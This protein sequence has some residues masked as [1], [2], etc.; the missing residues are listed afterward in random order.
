M[1][2]HICFIKCGNIATSTVV[3]LLLDEIAARTD[4][5]VTV[6]GSG[7]KMTPEE[8]GRI[9]GLLPSLAPDLV[10][11][12][13][14]NA[15]ALGMV[16]LRKRLGKMAVPGIIIGDGP[17]K[18][19]KAK[20]EEEGFGYLIMEADPLIG[21]RREF[22]DPSEMAIFNADVLKVLA[23]VG[24]LR[25]VAEELDR[26]ISSPGP[27]GYLPRKVVSESRSLAKA[28]FKN[29]YA[30]AKA[31]T[32]FNLVTQAAQVN[33]KG[34]FVER[35]PKKF[36]RMVATAHEM[37][38]AADRIADEAREIEKSSDS[39]LRTPHSRSGATLKKRSL[40]EKPKEANK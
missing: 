38:R 22:L 6:I 33:Y 18:R 21:A 36:M 27:E 7:A 30:R 34:C 5:T 1:M 16:R 14:P 11:V 12:C 8:T 26:A 3:E 10:V 23:V 25:V 13:G 15:G 2:V 40:N 19:V 20:L 32:A 4:L 35:D 24:S 29:P 9:A 37:V 28:G 17:S 39:V 31:A